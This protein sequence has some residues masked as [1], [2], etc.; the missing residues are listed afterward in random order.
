MIHEG[1]L[2]LKEMAEKYIEGLDALSTAEKAVL[3]R[4]AG[5]LLH[6]SRSGALGAFY[7]LLPPGVFSAQ[8]GIWFAVA[9][10]YFHTKTRLND[11]EKAMQWTQTNFG[12]TLRRALREGPRPDNQDVKLRALLDSACDLR[13]GHFFHQMRRLVHLAESKGVPVNWP[14]LL[15]DLISWNRPQRNVQKEWA[16]TYYSDKIA[17]EDESC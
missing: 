10:L 16:R 4:N 6:E 15:T 2:D 17:K 11:K 14:K 1:K 7:R 8:E 13:D 3:K 5:N 9:T 12:W